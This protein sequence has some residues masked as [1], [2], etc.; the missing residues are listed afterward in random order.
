MGDPRRID[1]AGEAGP[2]S[3]EWNAC[4]RAEWDRLLV[5][6][7][8]SS[9]EQSWSY[10]EALAA[11]AGLGVERAVL[12]KAGQP[13]AVVQAFR[14]RIGRLARVI[15][16]VRG[17]LVLAPDNRAEI[18][19][20]VRRSFHKRR[21]EFAFWLPE[22]AEGSDGIALMRSLGLRR[23]VSG[24]SSAW[25]D[26]TADLDTLRTGLAGNW[27][28]ALSAAEASPLKVA[29]D[30]GGKGLAGSMAELDRFR[31]GKRFSGPS[32]ALIVAIAEAG[33]RSKDVVH[34]RA[35]S[36]QETVAAVVLIR[37]GTAATYYASWTTAEGRLHR[38]HNL[39]L[40]R[41][42]AELKKAGTTWLDLGG[43]DTESTPGIARFKLG[44]GATPFTLSGTYF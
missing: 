33:R 37:H 24:Y 12:R 19:R 17:P 23:M 43:I 3:L 41:G 9:V 18:H 8:Q 34:L 28:N 4:K 35:V 38:A 11:T 21:R 2:I 29:M 10:G 7:G 20:A 5:A 44:L 39:L 16:I 6:A 14:R 1:G 36:G 32:G 26:L 22:L 40:W 13:V 30:D 15:R 27:R 31:R 42:I 25:L